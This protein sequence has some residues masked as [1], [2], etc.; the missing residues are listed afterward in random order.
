MNFHLKLT[1]LVLIYFFTI[2][3]TFS[4]FIFLDEPNSREN[5]N[6]NSLT[7]NQLNTEG[8]SMLEFKQTKEM[9]SALKLIPKNSEKINIL[10]KN[11]GIGRGQDH[12]TSS[13][14]QIKEE[15]LHNSHKK[16]KEEENI[17]LK[18]NEGSTI[19]VSQMNRASSES[20]E[21]KEGI[22]NNNKYLNTLPKSDV[23]QKKKEK[24]ILVRRSKG[25][26]NKK[27]LYNKKIFSDN[28]DSLKN[29]KN[30]ND[31]EDNKHKGMKDVQIQETKQMNT[32]EMEIKRRINELRGKLWK[33]HEEGKDH[34]ELEEHGKEDVKKM[35]IKGRIN[36]MNVNNQQNHPNQIKKENDTIPSIQQK[37]EHQK[38][39]KLGSHPSDVKT[40][41]PDVKTNPPSDDNKQLPAHPKLNKD[42][43]VDLVYTW[44][45]GSD[46]DFLRQMDMALKAINSSLK[47]N[48]YTKAR[49]FDGDELKYSLRSV[50]KYFDWYNKIY[51]VTNG[52]IPSWLN[53]SN[54]RIKVITHQEIFLNKKRSPY[55]LICCN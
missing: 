51:I 14:F 43:K 49:F 36:K 37:E 33:P 44:V 17:E 46:I 39:P 55:L 12:S 15:I 13:S 9:R 35:K 38:E 1:I 40:N 24:K 34:H 5:K 31:G 26:I 28:N 32:E 7:I 53:T 42:I 25:L 2:V 54:P 23:D 10:N 18:K 45:N 41:P 11:I 19:N 22:K 8:K 27:P 21:S 47:E 16:S 52:Q 50:E 48:E 3:F 4:Y 29:K 30:K 6:D 20:E